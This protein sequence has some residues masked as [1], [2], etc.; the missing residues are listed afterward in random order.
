MRRIKKSKNFTSQTKKVGVAN[1]KKRAIFLLMRIQI[2]DTLLVKREKVEI[3]Q[4]EE[5]ILQL[6]PEG[7]KEEENLQVKTVKCQNLARC[8]SKKRKLQTKLLKLVTT[9]KLQTLRNSHV[10]SSLLGTQ[11]QENL[12]SVVKWFI[13]WVSLMKELLINSKEKPKRKA[14]I[15][16]G[17]L[18]SWTKQKKREQKVKQQ[19]LEEPNS[20]LLRNSLLFLMLQDTKTMSQT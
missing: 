2:G 11:M 12:L 18:M 16:G 6:E 7:D 17:S 1:K 5:E 14:V 3:R 10:Q 20:I 13:K 8:L 9:L 4:E 19:R 15:L